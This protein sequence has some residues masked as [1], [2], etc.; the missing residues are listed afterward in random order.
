[1]RRY[2]TPLGFVAERG[3]GACVDQG[4]RCAA[5]LRYGLKA[6]WALGD[7]ATCEWVPQ[8][9]DGL[10]LQEDLLLCANGTPDH[11][12]GLARS[13]YPGMI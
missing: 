2:G 13:A 5:T 6:R 9:Y 12:E 11:S 10:T 4:S 1:M 7:V 3:R 8:Y